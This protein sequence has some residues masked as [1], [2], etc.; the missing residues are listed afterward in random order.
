MLL[1]PRSSPTVA[2]PTASRRGRN[3]L[4]TGLID[5]GLIWAGQVV[6][7]IDDIPSVEELLE[8]IIAECTERIANA[9][10]VVLATF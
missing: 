8:R 9:R 7:L 1:A 10:N 2:L 4:E 6:G 3:A 5:E